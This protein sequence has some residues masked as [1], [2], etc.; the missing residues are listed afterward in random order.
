M[1]VTDSKTGRFLSGN[2]GGPGRPVGA[3]NKLG[4][5]FIEAMQDD[6]ATHGK[7][8][9]EKVRAE[10]P[11]EYLKIVAAL[12]PKELHLKDTTLDDMADDDISEMLGAIRA[13]RAGRN[14]AASTAESGSENDQ[15]AARH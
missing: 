5:A 2:T 4:T 14:G 9:I 12:L 10:R 6:F 7:G 8:T 3:R 1:S 11:H 13:F 15:Q